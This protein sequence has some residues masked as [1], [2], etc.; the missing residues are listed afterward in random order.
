MA[1]SSQV[2]SRLGLVTL[3]RMTLRSPEEENKM[4]ADAVAANGTS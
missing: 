1:E 2:G 4:A 3:K